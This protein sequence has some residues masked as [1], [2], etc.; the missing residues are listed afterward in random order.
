MQNK[1]MTGVWRHMIRIPPFLWKKQV[2]R[3][4]KK[5]KAEI[6]FMTRE[7]RQVHHC[8]VRE[9]PRVGEPLKPEIVAEKLDLHVDR[10][11]AVLDDLEKHMT[12]LFRNPEGAV[13]WAYPVTVEKTPHHLTFNTGEQLYA[14]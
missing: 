11:K 6:G 13:V 12:F 1:L 10:V 3:M 4:T 14:A 9:L 7:D 5:V 2:S 8:V